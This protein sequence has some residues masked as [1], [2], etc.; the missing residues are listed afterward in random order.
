MKILY[1]IGSMQV[2]GAERHLLRI[3]SEL[4]QK[5]YAIEVF[6]FQPVGPLTSLFQAQSIPVLGF[7]APSWIAHWIPHKRTY[8]WL[9]LLIAGFRLLLTLWATRPNVIHFFLPAA[10]II[11]GLVSIFGPPCVRIMSRRSMNHYQAKHR[12]FAKVE[13]WLHPRMD[14][15]T[16]NS[17]AVVEQ[18]KDEGI[19]SGRLH[20][21][22]NGID[23]N[24]FYQPNLRQKIREQLGISERCL[25]MV[26]VANLIPYKGHADLIQAC[27]YIRTQMP[28]DWLLILVGRD[29]GIQKTLENQA[30]ALGVSDHL[31][32]LGSRHD[33]PG[34]LAASDV[35]VLSSHEEG[36]SNAVLEA[37][38][39]ALPMVVTDVGGNSEAVIDGVTGYVVPANDSTRLA[40]SLL[41]LSTDPQRMAM[42]QKAR[43][44]VKEHFSMQACLKGYEDLYHSDLNFLSRHRSS[45]KSTS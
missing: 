35:G 17:M 39:A 42:G 16:G 1:V 3:A 2:G 40:E 38:A 41:A 6:A 33:I 14:R 24:H 5:G 15:V 7:H 13:R 12:L 10:Y 23:A 45:K 32:F 26:M 19:Q 30:R 21:I 31:R 18:L 11:G 29:D 4:K 20:L 22:Y 37:M 28:E 34:L 9:T 36:F 44:R 43:K 8:A 27:A 25:V